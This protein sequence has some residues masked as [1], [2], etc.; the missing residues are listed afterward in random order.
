M[1]NDRSKRLLGMLGLAQRARMLTAGTEQTTDAARSG[2]AKMMIVT[3]DASKN[4]KK[5]IFNCAR[6][7]EVACYEVELTSEE[8]SNGIGK[9]GLC[10]A[11]AVLDANMTK[12]I[13]RLLNNDTKQQSSKADASSWEV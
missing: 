4:T 12:G 6:Y 1:M 9:K 13:E 11:C 3:F 7:Y 8:L 10:A 5:R 2:K